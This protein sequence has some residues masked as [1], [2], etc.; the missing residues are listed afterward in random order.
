MGIRRLV[1]PPVVVGL[2]Q[3][4]VESA[5]DSAT[6]SGRLPEDGVAVG[7]AFGA[8]FSAPTFTWNTTSS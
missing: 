3:E 6:A 4:S 1:Q 2:W 8:T 5:D 7:F